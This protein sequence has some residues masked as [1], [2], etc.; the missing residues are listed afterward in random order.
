MVMHF[1]SIGFFESHVHGSKHTSSDATPKQL[2]STL[3]AKSKAVVKLIL[4]VYFGTVA[5]NTFL[6]QTIQ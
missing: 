4:F 6:F 3:A 5:V 2:H 1:C